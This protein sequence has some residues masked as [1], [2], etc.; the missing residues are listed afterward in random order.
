L[1]ED[2]I[3]PKSEEV[4]QSAEGQRVADQETV[5]KKMGPMKPG[6]SVEDKTLFIG[7]CPMKQEP[8]IYGS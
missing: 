2:T 1:P 4:F 7:R 5:L 3:K 8:F 6:N